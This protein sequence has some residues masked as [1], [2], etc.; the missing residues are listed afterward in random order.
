MAEAKAKQLS[1][2]KERIAAIKARKLE[3]EKALKLFDVEAVEEKMIALES[4]GL[5]SSR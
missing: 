4:E 3:K 5:D 2:A 1:L